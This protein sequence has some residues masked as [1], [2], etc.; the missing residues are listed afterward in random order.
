MKSIVTAPNSGLL[1]PLD[2]VSAGFLDSS[3]FAALIEIA[4]VL[5]GAVGTPDERLA[6]GK[7][8]GVG[9]SGVIPRK[10]F[11]P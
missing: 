3:R 5:A 1:P 4:F 2:S 6:Y 9:Q 8:G 10:G 11:H 7:C